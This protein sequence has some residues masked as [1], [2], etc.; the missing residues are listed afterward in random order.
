VEAAEGSTVCLIRSSCGRAA[1]ARCIGS[2]TGRRGTANCRRP[3]GRWRRSRDRTHPV[4]ARYNKSARFVGHRENYCIIANIDCELEAY[5]TFM[6][7][8]NDCVHMRNTRGIKRVIRMHRLFIMSDRS[9]AVIR[10][11][12]VLEYIVVYAD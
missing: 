1:V 10:E 9:L 2:G 6:I 5:T 11:L 12:L 7:A 8:I 3:P 4:R